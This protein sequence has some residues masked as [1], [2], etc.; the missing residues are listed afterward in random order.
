MYEAHD[1]LVCIG[2]KNFVD[3]GNREN[4]AITLHQKNDDLLE[5]FNDIPEALE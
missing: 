3:D 5:L 1:A 4:L 2:Q